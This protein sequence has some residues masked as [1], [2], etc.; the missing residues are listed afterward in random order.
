M[1]EFTLNNLWELRAELD[2]AVISKEYDKIKAVKVKYQNMVEG[3]TWFN[4]AFICYNHGF[5]TDSD[6]ANHNFANVNSILKNIENYERRYIDGEDVSVKFKTQKTTRF[7][8]GEIWVLRAMFDKFIME[9]SKTSKYLL[10]QQN[11]ILGKAIKDRLMTLLGM[12]QNM[13]YY[14]QIRSILREVQEGY[15]SL[16]GNKQP[17]IDY[18]HISEDYMER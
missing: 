14:Y 15:E 12:D 11:M 17:K 3:E 1:K 7:L 5:W 18:Y 8:A 13:D 16:Y 4:R 9:G 2:N 6:R 10:V